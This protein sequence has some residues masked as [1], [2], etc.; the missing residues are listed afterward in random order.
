MQLKGTNIKCWENYVI[1]KSFFEL[2]RLIV[3]VGPCIVYRIR[4]TFSRNKNKFVFSFTFIYT[5]NIIEE[6]YPYTNL[7]EDNC[8][9]MGY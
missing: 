4:N 1:L 6:W 9:K 3:V 8:I 2:T 5:T 7:T